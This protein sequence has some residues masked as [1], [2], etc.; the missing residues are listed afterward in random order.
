MMK[1]TQSTYMESWD[2][3]LVELLVSQ[4]INPLVLFAISFS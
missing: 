1:G 4:A 2:N 3:E